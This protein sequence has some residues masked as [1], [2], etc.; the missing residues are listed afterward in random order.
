MVT[1]HPLEVLKVIEIYLQIVPTDFYFKC[2]LVFGLHTN[3]LLVVRYPSMQ[4]KLRT[5]CKRQTF[6]YAY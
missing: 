1:S 3:M 4:L 5:L 6:L 2:I